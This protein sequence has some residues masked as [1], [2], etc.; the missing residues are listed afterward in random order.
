MSAD[1]VATATRTKPSLRR[2]LACFALGVVTTIAV[3][4]AS[5]FINTDPRS[6]MPSWLVWG[7]VASD[8]DHVQPWR[9]AI[10]TPWHARTAYFEK[11]RVYNKPAAAPAG[12][13]STA[14]EGW[15]I[16]TS[17]RNMATRFDQRALAFSPAVQ[18]VIDATPWR[19]WSAGEESR[20]FPFPALRSTLFGTLDNASASIFTSPDSIVLENAPDGSGVVT[21][22][23]DSILT[24]R[25]LSYAPLWPGFL[26]NTVF[27]AIL[28]A[29]ILAAA[30]F[31]FATIT[32]KRA[33]AQG[34]CPR[35][36]YDLV[37]NHAGGCPECGWNRPI[38]QQIKAQADQTSGTERT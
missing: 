33:M 7:H 11:G 35:C 13:S 6:S 31:L 12:A 17:T 4:W 30:S 1:A 21:G 36:G 19:V 16:A 2:V 15:S 3:A 14:V 25:A 10:V 38:S 24:V 5:V 27:Y 8:G 18:A 23:R 37:G 28:W 29:I 26:A 22:R 20:G 34:R 9:L 32:G